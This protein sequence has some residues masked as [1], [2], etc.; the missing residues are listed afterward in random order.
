MPSPNS[1]ESEKEF[2]SRFMS[3]TEAISDY[4]DEKQRSAV[5]Y[6]MFKHRISL[7]NSEDWPKAY[8]CKFIEPGLVHYNEENIGTVL[9]KKEALDKMAQS[10]VGKPVINEIHKEVDPG[11][12]E[13]GEADGIVTKVYFN[14]TDGW[15]WAE[16]LVWDPATMM[17]CENKAYS[18][19]CAYNISQADDRQGVHNNIPYTQEVIDGAYTHLAVVA[20][21][22]YEGARIIYNS[23]GG[24]HM[25]FLKFWKSKKEKDEVKNASEVNIEN[26]MVNVDGKEVAVKEL[27]AVHNATEGKKPEMLSEETV[28]ELDGKEMP[29]KNLMDTYRKVKNAEDEDKKKADEAKN[30]EEEKKKKAEE[31]KNAEEADKKK[32]ED[33]MKNA[34]GEENF[35]ALENAARGRGEPQQPQIMS[36]RQ[37]ALE[38]AKRYGK[39]D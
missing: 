12:Y 38:G 19:S 37:M 26:A 21:P 4:P 2:V 5:A 30:A 3:S 34:K 13:S 28:I 22:R 31:A 36:R 33:E 17:N 25:K 9:V 35:E 23:K 7:N 10:F 1:G 18:V 32:K 20:N 6:S 14:Q 27:I 8:S 39:K 11:F 24:G 16:F 15:Y 29:L